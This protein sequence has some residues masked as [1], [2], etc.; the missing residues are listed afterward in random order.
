MLCMLQTYGQ[1]RNITGSVADSA[2]SPYPAPQSD[3]GTNI[4][5]AAGADGRYEIKV[6]NDNVT[7]IFYFHRFPGP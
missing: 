6:P 5:T 2:G 1:Q 7:L 4:G 3:K